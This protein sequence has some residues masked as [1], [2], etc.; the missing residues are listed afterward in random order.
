MESKHFYL[1][2]FLSQRGAYRL[3]SCI[4]K[5]V[6]SPPPYA[7]RAFPS[8]PRMIRLQSV[9]VVY[10]LAYVGIQLWSL[11]RRIPTCSRSHTWIRRSKYP[12]SL[13]SVF[14]SPFSPFSF[15]PCSLIP[16]FR[17]SP[18]SPFFQGI[19]FLFLC[20]LY[21]LSASYFV[22]LNFQFSAHIFFCTHLPF[23]PSFSSFPFFLFLFFPDFPFCSVS[24]HVVHSHVV[25]VSPLAIFLFSMSPFSYFL[26]FFSVWS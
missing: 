1:S 6:Y 10:C 4:P 24:L 18:F 22:S 12:F 5:F 7:S 17:F 16:S 21:L 2:P 23:S 13:L 25:S 15:L 11:L 14:F 3:N 8:P 20:F 19:L 26:W 9:S